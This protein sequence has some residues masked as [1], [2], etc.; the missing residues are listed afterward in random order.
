MHLTLNLFMKKVFLSAGALLAMTLFAHAQKTENV[1]PPP[2]PKPPTVVAPKKEVPPPPPPKIEV[3]SFQDEFLT[4]NKDLA[5]VRY[6]VGDK[7]VLT[8][9]D[10]TTEEYN[11]KDP[12][13]KKKFN[14]KY[15]EA[16]TPPPP[17]PPPPPVERKS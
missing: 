4:R 3:V 1:P 13:Q 6:K 17:P 2:P 14:E 7:I 15:G 9:K 11:L 8:K 12:V 5:S 10:K 16:P